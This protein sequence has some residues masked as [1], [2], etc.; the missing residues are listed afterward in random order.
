MRILKGVMHNSIKQ[1]MVCSFFKAV[2]VF[3]NRLLSLQRHFFAAKIARFFDQHE[4]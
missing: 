4:S 1:D 2:L 3:A